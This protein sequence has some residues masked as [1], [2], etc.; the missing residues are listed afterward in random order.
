LSDTSA[1]VLPRTALAGCIFA[2]IVR[3]TRGVA[4]SDA[5]RFNFFP[6]SPLVTL[7]RIF[8]GET[9][10][11]SGDGWPQDAR[12]ARPLGAITLS[13]PQSRPLASWN[14]GPVHAVSI[15][16]YP[17]AW[18]KLTGMSPETL[19]DRTVAARSGALPEILE[20]CPGED[21][22]AFWQEFENT[23]EPLWEDVRNRGGLPPW[24]GG[25]RIADWS[26]S[27]VARGIV[28]GPGRSARAIQRRL[29]RWTG[30]NRQALSVTARIE[31]LHG[32]V[33]RNGASQPAVTAVEAGFADQSHMGREV[34]RATGFS[35][36]RL[37][38]MIETSEAFWCYRLL[39]ERF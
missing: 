34:L 20:N 10:L 27:L 18:M 30:Q 24:T 4:L 17:E 11:A 12:S 15:S 38:R 13:G 3:D 29:R 39:G 21:I 19:V 32:L 8:E 7:T 22:H 26:R 6:G 23:V 9:R 25:N 33:T 14:P 36:V 2:A 35:P 28:S 16:F 31:D 5:E 1:L 37:N